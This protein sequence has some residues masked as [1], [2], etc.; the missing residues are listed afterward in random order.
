MKKEKELRK[1]NYKGDNYY[2][3]IDEEKK[4]SVMKKCREKGEKRKE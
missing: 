2:R 1:E 3:K 4:V